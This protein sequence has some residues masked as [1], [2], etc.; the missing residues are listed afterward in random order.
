MLCVLLYNFRSTLENDV[1][2]N[3]SDNLN[4]FLV[5]SFVV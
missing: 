5:V 2:I 4:Y 3:G 1:S